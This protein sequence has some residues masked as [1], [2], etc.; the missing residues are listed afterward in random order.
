MNQHILTLIAL[1]LGADFS[2]RAAVLFSNFGP[3]DDFS[4]IGRVVEGP[5]GGGI[6][7]VDQAVSFRVGPAPWLVTDAEVGIWVNEPP[8]A[9]T[10]P[11]DI[12]LAS[13]AGGVPGAALQ[14]A[15]LNI[16]VTGKQIAMAPLGGLILDA[17]TTYWL[18]VDGEG[19]FSGSYLF[20]T[21][22]DI[23]DTAGRTDG[24]PWN[25]R[26]DDDRYALRL[27]G[28]VIPEPSALASAAVTLLGAVG[29]VRFQR[30]RTSP[31]VAVTQG[32]TT[33]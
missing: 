33:R 26:E 13:D 23:G 27:N 4:N 8:N 24:F 14:T 32:E 29:F 11:L 22:G 10:G 31:K 6:G 15:N 20:N 19:T 1:G 30:R 21:I 12:F 18:V 16:N 2:A 17:N 3:G 7:D 9:G 28:R 25:L 5:A